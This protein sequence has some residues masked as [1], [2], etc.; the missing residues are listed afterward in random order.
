MI[1]SYTAEIASLK[2]GGRLS[3][4]APSNGRIQEDNA[5]VS[6]SLPSSS[7]PA[8]DRIPHATLHPKSSPWGQAQFPGSN[9]SQSEA[10]QTFLGGDHS[11]LP[12]PSSY[13]S[14]NL[15]SD[16]GLLSRSVLS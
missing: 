3:S 7:V 14:T 12:G 1:S 13:L 9:S 6:Q 2:N 15:N 11:R 8:E 10:S 5:A 16:V 4:A